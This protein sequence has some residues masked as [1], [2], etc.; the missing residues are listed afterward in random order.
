MENEPFETAY[1]RWLRERGESVWTHSKR[2]KLNLMALRRLAGIAA[3][4]YVIDDFSY[5]FLLAVSVES[6]IEIE[7]LVEDA[8]R[9][10]KQP[11]PPRRP[12]RPRKE[13][14]TDGK[15]AE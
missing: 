8:L 4:A 7:R 5:N 15:A 14:R 12:G 9:A 1:A 3:E 10:A 2:T 11:T 13:E 6:G